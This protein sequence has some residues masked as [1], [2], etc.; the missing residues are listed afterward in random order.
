[1]LLHDKIGV[2]EK[3]DLNG[4]KNLHICIICQS[5]HFLN[6]NFNYKPKSY[7]GCHNLLMKSLK[8]NY[9]TV[10]SVNHINYRIH[11]FLKKKL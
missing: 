7:Q 5:G 1:M 6:V 8:F 4:G 11:L 3:S 9:V 10:I 2:S